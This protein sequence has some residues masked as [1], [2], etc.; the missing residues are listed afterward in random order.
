MAR[1]ITTSTDKYGRTVYKITG[2]K[3]YA[4]SLVKAKKIAASLDGGAVRKPAKKTARKTTRRPAKRTTAVTRY[5][6]R[7]GKADSRFKGYDGLEMDEPMTAAERRAVLAAAKAGN[8][9]RKPAKRTTAKRNASGQFVK[10]T[11][12]KKTTRRNAGR[13]SEAQLKAAIAK[14][15]ARQ[16]A[17]KGTLTLAQTKAIARTAYFLA[18]G[19]MNGATAEVNAS[20]K[21]AGRIGGDLYGY[22]AQNPNTIVEATDEHPELAAKGYFDDSGYAYEWE[23]H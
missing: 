1:K 2:T 11:A 4:F 17:K 13:M 23:S 21:K 14:V 8:R 10:R 22:L 6:G 19:S 3:K 18:N 9:K 7:G 15:R 5:R 20:V 16:R 12:A